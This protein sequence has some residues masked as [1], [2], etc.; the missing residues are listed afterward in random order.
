MIFFFLTRGLA[1]YL[2]LINIFRLT[3]GANLLGALKRKVALICTQ[4]YAMDK[5]LFS[6]SLRCKIK[7]YSLSGGKGTALEKKF[8]KME[9]QS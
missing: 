9:N 3:G 8:T 2:V 4:F 7:M 6:I 1:G 5:I